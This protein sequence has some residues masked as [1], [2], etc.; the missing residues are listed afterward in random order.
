MIETS[1]SPSFRYNVYAAEAEFQAYDGR[2]RVSFWGSFGARFHHQ[3][4]RATP[5]DARLSP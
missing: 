1:H 2:P 4:C 3:F 5:K